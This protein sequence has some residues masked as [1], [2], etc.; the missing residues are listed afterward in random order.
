MVG[1]MVLCFTPP[2]W[3]LTRNLAFTDPSLGPSLVKMG[4]Y[5]CA[6]SLC[7]CVFRRVIPGFEKTGYFG[8]KSEQEPPSP[9]LVRRLSPDFAEPILRLSVRDHFVDV[10]SLTG[11]EAIRMRFADAID[12]MDTVIGYCTHRSHWV[13]RNAIVGVKREN[14]KICLELING[15]LVPVSRKYKP[16]LEAVGLL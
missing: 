8:P 7:I 1:L 12:E 3:F 6:I 10:V 13:A 2:L 9:R 11:H 16:E 4:Y 15:D 14:G 5:V